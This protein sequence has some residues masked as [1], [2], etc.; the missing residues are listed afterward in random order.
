MMK[1]MNT[2]ELGGRIYRTGSE[3]D[4]HC[5]VDGTRLIEWLDSETD[6]RVCPNCGGYFLVGD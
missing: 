2:Y 3:T 5:P 6:N 4:D 1:P